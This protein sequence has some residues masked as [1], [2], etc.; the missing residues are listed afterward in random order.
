MTFQPVV[1]NLGTELLGLLCPQYSIRNISLSHFPFKGNFAIHAVALAAL[2]AL[3]RYL[4]ST[5]Y[6]NGGEEASDEI[7]AHHVY[8]IY[9]N[10][11]VT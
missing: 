4:S 7:E 10:K 11:F 1:S 3:A 2:L 8:I 6:D 5:L 9:C